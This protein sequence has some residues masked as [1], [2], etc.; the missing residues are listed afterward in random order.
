MRKIDLRPGLRHTLSTKKRQNPS[1]RKSGW[2]L[3]SPRR[4]RAMA[5]ATE[6]M[7]HRNAQTHQLTADSVLRLLKAMADMVTHPT[8]PRMRGAKPWRSRAKRANTVGAKNQTLAV[9]APPTQGRIANAPNPQRLAEEADVSNQ[10][11]LTFLAFARR[12]SQASNRQANSVEPQP[13]VAAW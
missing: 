4:S 7:A 6:W 13:K 1:A 12:H 10:V 9:S 11:D 3:V 2:I 8:S 5:N